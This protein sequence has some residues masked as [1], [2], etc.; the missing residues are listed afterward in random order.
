MLNV[1]TS[2][3]TVLQRRDT[4]HRYDYLIHLRKIAVALR[5]VVAQRS[6]MVSASP[7]LSVFNWFL[8]QF[9]LSLCAFGVYLSIA[10][11]SWINETTTELWYKFLSYF[12]TFSTVLVPH[13]I[14]IRWFR[15][16]SLSSMDRAIY[17]TCVRA[18]D[19][20]QKRVKCRERSLSMSVRNWTWLRTTIAI[21]CVSLA[22]ELRQDCNWDN[23]SSASRT[24][25]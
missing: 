23:P 22:S 9:I 21:A 15:N 4:K 2:Y 25:G 19:A 6:L 3:F 18:L 11:L 17:T 5:G 16:Q 10:L 1:F 20:R 13:F 8:A 24:H 7:T 14:Y 12:S